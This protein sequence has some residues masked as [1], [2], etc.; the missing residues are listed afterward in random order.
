MNYIIEALLVGTYSALLYMLFSPFINNIFI[1]L[2][3]IGFLKHYLSYY[4]G[5][6]TFYCRY[7]EACKKY[8]TYKLKENTFLLYE[9]IV[10]ALLYLLVGTVLYYTI[11]NKSI[12][13]FFLI[14]FIL[15]ILFEKLELHSKFCRERC[16]LNII[17]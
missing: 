12:Y 11:T 3:V 14:G 5:L 6:H 7:G 15:H 10:E 2:L 16:A 8:N 9:S 1:L 17:E 4:I 13:I